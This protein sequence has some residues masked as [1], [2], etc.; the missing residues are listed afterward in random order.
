M[1][2]RVIPLIVVLAL[3][4]IVASVGCAKA[5]PTPQPATPAPTPAAP[6]W[7][8]R[9]AQYTPVSDEPG[10]TGAITFADAFIHLLI[11]LAFSTLG[12]LVLLD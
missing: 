7:K 8:L 3:A 2:K 1:R 12:D 10:W 9:F 5:T 6:Q 4:V 11:L